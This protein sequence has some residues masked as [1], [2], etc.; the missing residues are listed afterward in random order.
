M[1][2]VVEGCAARDGDP[3]ARSSTPTANSS[4]SCGGS[5]TT[6]SLGVDARCIQISRTL[7]KLACSSRSVLAIRFATLAQA[8]RTS[9]C[10]NT[11]T[12]NRTRGSGR[13]APR[14]S[15][16]KMLRNDA[17]RSVQLEGQCHHV[18]R[19]APGAYVPLGTR[20]PTAAN[21]FTY[22]F[23]RE[24]GRGIFE[25]TRGAETTERL[26]SRCR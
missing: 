25:I 19:P 9:T 22:A 16:Y 13:R 20:Y 1:S 15:E 8:E 18:Q 7:S 10:A 21:P 2:L 11:S 5:T 12:S 17:G 6:L 3:A 24:A 23:E 26:V 14:G 4:A